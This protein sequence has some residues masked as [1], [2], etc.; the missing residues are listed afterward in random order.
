MLKHHLLSLSLLSSL[1]LVA[2]GSSTTNSGTTA[3]P[4]GATGNPVVAPT[5][6]PEI[7][8]GKDDTSRC[9]KWQVRCVKDCQVLPE[10]EYRDACTTQC[11]DLRPSCEETC[12]ASED[13]ESFDPLS[14]WEEVPE[15]P[16]AF[17][18]D[19]GGIDQDACTDLRKYDPCQP[20][21]TGLSV[22]NASRCFGTC[23]KP[24]KQGINP[25]TFVDDCDGTHLCSATKEDGNVCI[26]ADCNPTQSANSCAFPLDRCNGQFAKKPDFGLCDLTC[27]TEEKDS[28]PAAQ[29]C[30]QQLTQQNGALYPVNVCVP[31]AA[32]TLKAIGESCTLTVTVGASGVTDASE[33]CVEGALCAALAAGAGGA[34]DFKC[35]KSCWDKVN[36]KQFGGL[37]TTEGTQCTP[38]GMQANALGLPQGN[39][40]L[41][42]PQ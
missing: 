24:A 11:E 42:I 27:R 5:A 30:Y 16:K 4:S 18:N 19:C 25:K 33:N 9:G 21:L 8:C 36:N 35:Y 41:C 40:Y 22:G 31:K 12:V 2:C 26:P 20:G 15:K 34:P 1:A 10:G 6:T 39:Q 32:G 14:D 3:G 23:E 29:N 28:C 37:C 17:S 13:P 7:I 38:V